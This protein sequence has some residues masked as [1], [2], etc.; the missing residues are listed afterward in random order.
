MYDGACHDTTS[1]IFRAYETNISPSRILGCVAQLEFG[2]THRDTLPLPTIGQ[3]TSAYVSRQC[4]P[5]II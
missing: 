5:F 4:P 1:S 2:T 3:L